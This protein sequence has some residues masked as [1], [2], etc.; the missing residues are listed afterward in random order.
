[1][2]T[3]TTKEKGGSQIIFRRVNLLIKLLNCV[4]NTIG[5]YQKNKY[6]PSIF[7]I[8]AT[9]MIILNQKTLLPLRV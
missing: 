9:K 2:I 3:I 4:E 6:F 7:D 8:S 5:K 1:M